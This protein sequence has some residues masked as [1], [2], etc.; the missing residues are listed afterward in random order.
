MATIAFAT[1]LEHGHLLPTF[2]LA[3]ALKAR[4][5]QV[6]YL[7]DSANQNLIRSQGFDTLTVEGWMEL[8][9]PMTLSDNHI[10]SSEIFYRCA[11]KIAEA[12]REVRIDLLIVDSFVPSA[13][14]LAHQQKI[15]YLLLHTNLDTATAVMLMNRAVDNL[16]NRWDA[17][18]RFLKV[19]QLVLC[20]SE[21]D[22]KHPEGRSQGVYNIEASIDLERKEASLPQDR[23]DAHRPLIYCSL[24]SQRHL[25][26]E[27]RHFFQTVIDAMGFHSDLQMIVSVGEGL[28]S[29]D[30][31][32]ITSNI[33]VMNW[34]PQLEILKK[35]RLM[36][37]H[38]GLGTIKECIYF[39]VPMIVF[40]MS[41]EQPLN[42]ARV[43][44]HGLGIR[45]DIHKI[46]VEQMRDLISKAM[47]NEDSYHRVEVMKNMFRESEASGK[48]V[49]II[50]NIV[51]LIRTQY[52]FP[53]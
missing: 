48:G 12:D 41:R 1:L 25:Y 18:T 23:I 14:L 37:T 47:R 45:G 32:R 29:S 46:N 9:S 53:R 19:P 8:A 44:Y 4:G 21:F 42:A 51:H 28:G 49:K 27:T 50:E 17:P 34:A 33:A 7:M 6:F 35:A 10:L 24:G 16:A 22:F 26:A 5:H 30:F 39:G 20:P 13:A 43:V 36:I 40:P 31:S 38:G 15:P 2:K 52:N 3:R 11:N